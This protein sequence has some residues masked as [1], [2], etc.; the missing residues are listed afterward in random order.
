MDSKLV[1]RN[2]SIDFFRYICAIM[3]IAIHTKPFT[4]VNGNLGFIFSEITTRVG[5]PFFFCVSGYYY[6]QKLENGRPLNKYLIKLMLPYVVW[7]CVYFLLDF[8][9]WGHEDLSSFAFNCIYGFFISGSY[10]HFWFF[11]ALIYSVILTTIIF[12]SKLKKLLIPISIVLYIFGCIGCAYY[13]ISVNIPVFGKLFESQYF[14]L[15]RR[16]LLM[17][18]PF[19]ISGYVVFKLNSHFSKNFSQI[20]SLSAI[21]ISTLLWLSEIYIVCKFE[22]QKNIVITLFLYPL[23]VAIMLY[24]VN[25]PH[26]E[27]YKISNHTGVIANFAY[28]SHPLLIVIINKIYSTVLNDGISETTMFILV[29]I[30]ATLLGYILSCSQNKIIRKIIC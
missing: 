6:I 26:R 14:D 9:Q 10:Y 7:S 28:Y 4:D 30:I 27:L 20:K 17:G 2:S 22:I 1:S 19:F 15:I 5:V 23:L 12:K 21:F 8:I 13:K 18:F 3:V 25:Y 29:V 16:I 11:P 24:L